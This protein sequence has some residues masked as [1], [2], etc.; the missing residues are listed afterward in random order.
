MRRHFLIV[1]LALVLVFEAVIIV[2]T[3]VIKEKP[4]EPKI[5]VVVEVVREAPLV[6]LV[7]DDFGYT[8]ENLDLLR[9]MGVPVTMAVLPNLSYSKEVCRFAEDNGMEVILHFPMEPAVD[10]GSLEKETIM[11]DFDEVT[12]KRILDSDLASIDSAKGISNHMGSKATSDPRVMAIVF[13][14][15]KTRDMFFLD[16]VTTPESAGE[17]AARKVGLPYARRDIFIDHD[18]D[19][20]HIKKQMEKVE[21]IAVGKGSA[22]AIGH[23]RKGTI[24]ILT[25]I[26]PPMKERGIK[27]VKLSEL[28]EAKRVK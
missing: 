10:T 16:S 26:I 17:E 14:E 28:I 12:I 4:Q 15:L 18:A 6:A 20:E 22:I 3:Y 2:K 27:F 5:E 9:A 19:T 7:L 1:F 24:E 11:V 25:E 13:N 8:K 21:K 23:D